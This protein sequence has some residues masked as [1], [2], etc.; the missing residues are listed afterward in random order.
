MDNDQKEL[1]KV[2]AE[3]AMKPFADL[4]S[5]LFGGLAEQVG[6][7]M[8]DAAA[9]RRYV[10]RIKL[11]GNVQKKIE[12]SGFDPKAIPDKIWTPLLQAALLEDDET[13][14]D[15]WANLLANAADPGQ[16]AAV[17]PSFPLILRELT[18][19]D[20][21]LLSNT[22]DAVISGLGPYIRKEA[23]A[24]LELRTSADHFSL[25]VTLSVLERNNLMIRR[26]RVFLDHRASTSRDSEATVAYDYQLTDLAK[27]FVKA[28][29]APKK[30]N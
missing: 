11:F 24:N 12:E 18:P 6:G 20:A 13:L 2:G 27:M 30:T 29:R 15:M 14:Q 3:T 5:K 9:A 16:S 21:V 7:M 23:I 26:V 1:L 4:I 28:C 10:R 25:D 22:Y 17:L 8:T 19:R